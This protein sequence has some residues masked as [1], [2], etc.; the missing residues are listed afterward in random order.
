MRDKSSGD[1]TNKIDHTN[2]SFVS[3][4][5]KYQPSPP[6][7]SSLHNVTAPAQSQQQQ[8]QCSSQNHQITYDTQQHPT[9]IPIYQQYNSQIQQLS[10]SPP[11]YLANSPKNQFILNGRKTNS[12]PPPL[13]QSSSKFN[14]YGQKDSVQCSTVDYGNQ[15]NVYSNNMYGRTMAQHQQ[16]LQQASIDRRGSNGSSSGGGVGGNISDN[17][18]KKLNGSNNDGLRDDQGKLF[19]Y[20]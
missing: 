13:P 6:P 12:P 8:Q 11:Q 14:V 10:S 16:L 3:N 9:N 4:I 5:P 7:Y 2:S 19:L 18:G 20:I 15:Q 17:F 1:K